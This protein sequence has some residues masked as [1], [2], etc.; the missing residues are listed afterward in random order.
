[1]NLQVRFLFYKWAVRVFIGVVDYFWDICEVISSRTAE[2][3]DQ[4]QQGMCVLSSLCDGK[5]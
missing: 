4:N 5:M 3:F 2:L 1:M